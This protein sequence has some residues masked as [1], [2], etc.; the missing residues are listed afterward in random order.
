MNWDLLLLRN[1]SPSLVVK[2]DRR[3]RKVRT[4]TGP[5]MTGTIQT[6]IFYF[7]PWV[8]HVKWVFLHLHWLDSFACRL[9]ITTPFIE[10]TSVSLGVRAGIPNEKSAT[11]RRKSLRTWFYWRI[12]R[13]FYNRH[14][15]SSPRY[16]YFY[17]RSPN[18][19]ELQILG[20]TTFRDG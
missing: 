7:R 13:D 6:K 11:S 15:D 4:T 10:S 19:G 2:Y 3:S 12:P 20:D 16:R 5:K 9:R 18:I 14:L 17:K 8:F 1:T